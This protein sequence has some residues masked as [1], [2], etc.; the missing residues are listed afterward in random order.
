MLDWGLGHTTRCIPIIEELIQR[1]FNVIVA[2][3]DTQVKVLRVEFP[4]L[5][6][7]V[8]EGYN[9]HYTNR[10]WLLAISMMTQMPGIISN[11]RR[12]K[13]WIRSFSREQNIDIIISDNR[14]GFRNNNIHSIY[15]T[16]QLTV[17]TGNKFTEKFATLLH[18]F[19]IKNFDEC[20]IPDSIQNSLSGELS[21]NNAKSIIPKFIGPLSRFELLSIEKQYDIAIILSG[22]E[23]QRTLFEHTILNQIKSSNQK[24]IFVRGLPNESSELQSPKNILIRNHLPA[25]EMNRVICASSIVISRS[26][27]TSI[28]DYA[29]LQAKAI[30]VPTPG[31]GEQEYLAKYLSEKKY[32]M[33]CTQYNF[34]LDKYV[35]ESKK[36]PFEMANVDFEQFRAT[37]KDLKKRVK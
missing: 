9:I 19:Y 32:F 14:P 29:K 35:D 33:S 11:I 18:R 36:F 2:G 30:L 34:S 13:A 5:E 4:N 8:I 1:D 20:W 15:L 26:G 31:Q 22:P 24:I 28:M 16:H 3:T 6:Y 37:L 21:R 23:P 10:K 17:K 12:E 25:S 27:Y 7:H